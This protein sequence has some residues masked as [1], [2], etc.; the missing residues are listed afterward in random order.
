MAHLRNRVINQTSL[1]A[2]PIWSGSQVA[3]NPGTPAIGG[4]TSA[5]GLEALRSLAGVYLAGA[6][7]VE[8]LPDRDHAQV[9]ALLAAQVGFECLALAAL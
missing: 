2:K 1:Q 4:L 9:T 8:V 7:V 5:E 3:L 6:D